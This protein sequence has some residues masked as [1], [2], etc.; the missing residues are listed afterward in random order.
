VILDIAFTESIPIAIHTL[1]SGPSPPIPFVDHA[2]PP[3]D[4]S[5]SLLIKLSCVD[6]DAQGQPLEVV[7]LKNARGGKRESKL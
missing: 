7:P 5:Y 1:S 4:S 3:P 6:D 2:I